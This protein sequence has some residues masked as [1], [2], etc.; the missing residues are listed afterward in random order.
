M[1]IHRMVKAVA[2][3]VIA[4]FAVGSAQLARADNIGLFTIS[5]TWAPTCVDPT[6]QPIFG[7]TPTP[8][9]FA[10]DL[11][12]DVTNGSVDSMDVLFADAHNVY[13]YG[14]APYYPPPSAGPG[15]NAFLIQLPELFPLPVGSYLQLIFTTA[16]PGSLV[17]F[18]GGTILSGGYGYSGVYDLGLSKFYDIL[19]GSITPVTSTPEPSALAL[20]LFGLGACSLLMLRKAKNAQ[21]SRPYRRAGA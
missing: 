19:G 14:T 17:G 12:V 8:A 2:I 5:G 6:G 7:C 16:E 3:F 10:G 20:L 1:K 9:G 11:G 15:Y 21:P 4:L 18:D 13:E